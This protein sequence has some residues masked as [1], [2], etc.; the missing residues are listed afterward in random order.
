MAF[1]PFTL[2]G[3]AAALGGFLQQLWPPFSAACI[4]LSP[5]HISKSVLLS[6][7]LSLT[8]WGGAQ[9]Q[10]NFT[11]PASAGNTAAIVPLSKSS[12]DTYDPL[13][14]LPPL[15]HEKVALTGGT[16]TQVDHVLNCMTIRPFGSKQQMRMDFDMRSGVFQDEKPAQGKDIRVGERVYVDT[17]LNGTRV[18]AKTIRIVTAVSSGSGTGQILDYDASA[19]MLTLRDE[20]SDQPL[21]F[22]LTPSTVVH[23]GSEA[24]SLADLRP[25]SLVSLTFTDQQGHTVVRDVALLAQPGAEFSFFGKVTY[26]DLSQK[27]IAVANENDGKTYEIQLASV[28]QSVLRNLHQ[29]NV[30][31]VKAVF[32]GKQY[33]ARNVMQATSQQEE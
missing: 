20:L 13:L 6:L 29:G 33:T 32:D 18:F 31:G 24:R 28:P 17:Q 11:T 16:V 9:T 12:I 1:Q 10:S 7:V 26:L 3:K 19:N 21:H 5:M 14:D 30:V 4:Q 27:V 25:G 22:R 8:L 15:L 2:A 23:S